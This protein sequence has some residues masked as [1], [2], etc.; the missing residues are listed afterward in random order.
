MSVLEFVILQ[1][2][3]GLLSNVA[4]LLIKIR[5]VQDKPPY[6]TNIPYSTNVPENV[7]EVSIF[8]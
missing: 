2:G 7:T 5:D 3:D 1:D 6:F 8:T 4:N